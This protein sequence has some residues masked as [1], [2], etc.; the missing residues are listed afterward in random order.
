MVNQV[1]QDK[2][3]PILGGTSANFTKWGSIP[4]RLSAAR[5]IVANGIYYLDNPFPA[6]QEVKGSY[7]IVRVCNGE[8]TEIRPGN[9]PTADL[10]SL[11]K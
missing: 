9:V 4:Y 10:I 2:P 8:V 7:T 5:F 6:T 11:I 1:T 3:V